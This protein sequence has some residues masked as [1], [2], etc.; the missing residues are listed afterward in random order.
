MNSADAVVA[1]GYRLRVLPSV[2]QLGCE[3][4]TAY[5]GQ[6]GV[7]LRVGSKE[8]SGK[9]AIAESEDAFEAMDEDLRHGP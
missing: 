1:V 7:L 3:L 4:V 5:R 8:D 6:L 2:A 9:R